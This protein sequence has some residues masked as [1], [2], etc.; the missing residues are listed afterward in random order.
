MQENAIIVQFCDVICFRSFN[1]AFKTS[2]SYSI[3]R[4][5]Q[6]YA[7]GHITLYFSAGV[8]NSNLSKHGRVWLI[9][10]HT[11]SKTQII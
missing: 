3:M 2:G 10:G 9:N 6:I 5:K 4:E 1:V 7:H 11:I 8:L